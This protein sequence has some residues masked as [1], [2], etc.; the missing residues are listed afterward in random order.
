M[1][2][3]EKI[4]EEIKEIETEIIMG[5]LKLCKAHTSWKTKK[6][7]VWS[8]SKAKTNFVKRLR[9]DIKTLLNLQL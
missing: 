6:G 5:A 4:I 9:A 3:T 7:S 1:T 2:P 8:F